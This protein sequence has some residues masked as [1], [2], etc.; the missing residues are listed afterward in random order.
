MVGRVFESQGGWIAMEDRYRG[1]TGCSI[2]DGMADAG[3]GY[4]SMAVGTGSVSVGHGDVSVTLRAVRLEQ[5]V[6]KSE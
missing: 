4:C 3:S 6:S 5:S 1:L 2:A